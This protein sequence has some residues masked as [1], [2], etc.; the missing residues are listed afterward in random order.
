MKILIVTQYF[1]PENFKIND[2]ACGLKENDNEVTVLTG[3]PNYPKGKFFQG[4]SLFA[5]KEN[6]NGIIIKRVPIFPRGNSGV[7]GLTLNYL[8]FVLSAGFFS[9]F[10]CHQK[11]DVIFVFALSP[12]TSAL[13]G[14][15]LKKIKKIVLFIWILD[16]WPESLPAAN[17][18]SSTFFISC[19]DKL[20]RFIYKQCDFVLISSEGFKSSVNSRGVNLDKIVF[21]PNW[22]E[23]IYKPVTLD[24]AKLS[25]SR[26]AL[27]NGFRL[28]FAGNI[29]VAQDFKTILSAFEILKDYKDIHLIVLGEGRM[30]PW[31]KE[32]IRIRNLAGQVHLL[33]AFPVERMADF[34]SVADAMLVT[35]KKDYVF[36]MTI[37]GKL[38]SYLACAK[39]I[40]GALDGEGRKLLKT[41]NSGFVCFPGDPIA[42][43]NI[44][45]KMY[46]ASPSGRENMGINGREYYEQNFD[47]DKTIDKLNDLM[48]LSLSRNIRKD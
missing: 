1:W 48:K 14:V 27:P 26:I 4:Y 9:L 7:F 15:V 18:V 22:A 12:L 37:P 20:V 36:S 8:S 11:Y 25:L 40:V 23:N 44:I 35:L 32:Q 3:I 10:Y 19:I 30:Y 2:L 39:P 47:R 33:G 21:F 29:G 41:S 46:Q 6:Y 34:F 5:G 13:P 17:A 42:L 28:M 16:L 24:H 45:L 38:Q 43:S 31:V